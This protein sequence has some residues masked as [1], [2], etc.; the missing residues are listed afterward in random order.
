M[1]IIK[2]TVI[3]ARKKLTIFGYFNSSNH[4]SSEPSQKWLTKYKMSIC[5]KK[6]YQNFLN[7]YLP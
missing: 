3:L 4:C 1:L 7:I 5:M 6:I 2:H